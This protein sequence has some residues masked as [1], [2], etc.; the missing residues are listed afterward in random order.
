[1]EDAGVIQLCNRGMRVRRGASSL[2]LAGVD[3]LTAGKPDLEAALAGLHNDEPALL[4]SHHPDLFR[5]AAYAGVDL[6]LSGH[7]HGGQITW[8]GRPLLRGTHHTRFRYWHGRHYQDGAQ[9]LVGRG[10][11]VCV[12]PIRI[13][14]APE[15]LL[16][17]LQ[18]PAR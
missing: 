7:T 3:D 12:L 18:T 2:W 9:L 10:V 11:G 15:V 1:M 14:A 4:L 13:A 5:E 6:T 8:F 17:E 16:I